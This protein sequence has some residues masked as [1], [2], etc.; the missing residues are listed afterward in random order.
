VRSPRIDVRAPASLEPDAARLRQFDP[1]RLLAVMRLVGLDDPGADIRVYLVPEEAP[2]AAAVPDWIVAFAHDDQVVLFPRRT[3]SYPHESLQ[4]VLEHEVGH[5]LTSRA[6]GGRPVPRWFHEGVAMA[7]ERSWTLGDRARFVSDTAFGGAPSA[8]RLDRLFVEGPA[9]AERAYRL[10]DALM[11]DLT[12]RHGA[13]VPAR[14]LRAMRQGASFE[15]AFLDTTGLTVS[16]AVLAF[17]HRQRLWVTWL[18]WVTSP[19]AVYALM[20]LVAVAAVLRA[21]VRRRRRRTWADEIDQEAGAP[22]DPVVPRS[23]SSP[24]G[25]PRVQ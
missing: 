21:W 23:A 14:V 24:D 18:P 2:L 6:A 22:H 16:D 19:N 9:G 3:P 12:E 25:P 7:A 15:R 13:D 10:S 1:R 11:R 17:W 20:T 8:P 4:Q 5:V